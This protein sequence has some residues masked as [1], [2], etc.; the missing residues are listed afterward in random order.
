MLGAIVLTVL[1]AN[2]SLELP[3][4]TQT[5]PAQQPPASTGLTKP[6]QPWPPAG[7]IRPT[8]GVTV[9]RLLS[10]VK[11]KYTPAAM[12]AKIEGTVWLEAVIEPD[13][14]VGE[15]RVVR[16]LDREFGLDEEAINAVKKWRFEPGKKDG[17]AV[18]VL[19]EVEMTFTLRKKF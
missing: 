16:T 4:A 17:V 18:A 8:A 12:R 15:V 2:A 3:V 6:E 1:V 5:S 7:V 9:P 14:K 10:E 19:V 11:P 13:G